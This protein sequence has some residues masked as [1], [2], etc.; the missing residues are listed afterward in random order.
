MPL[1]EYFEALERLKNGRPEKIPK[2]SKITNDAVSLEA[3]RNK[4]SIKRSRPAFADLIQA[5]DEAAQSQAK[6]KNGL[7]ERAYAEKEKSERY[8][9]LWEEA[10][11]REVS[12]LH[13]LLELKQRLA[14]LSGENILPLRPQNTK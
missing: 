5:I 10:I 12:L 14:K 8:K 1:D 13:E 9:V 6:P 11:A 4:G 3:G 7:K 2:G